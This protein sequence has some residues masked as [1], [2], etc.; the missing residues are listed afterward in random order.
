ML[1]CSD[2][3]LYVGRSD[4]LAE[5]LQQHYEGRGCCYT[6]NRLP[7]TLVYSEVFES[8]LAAG[9]RERQ[10]K[11]WTTAKKEA[12]IQKDAKRLRMLATRRQYRAR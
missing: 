7:V 2:G 6:A 5:R 10:I 8:P 11:R 4:D 12:L 1:R 9:N 3:S